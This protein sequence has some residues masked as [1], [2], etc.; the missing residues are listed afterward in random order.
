MPNVLTIDKRFKELLKEKA[1]S[2]RREVPVGFYDRFLMIVQPSGTRSWVLRYGN[3]KLTIGPVLETRSG[4]RP[5]L[6]YDLPMTLH[7]ALEFLKEPLQ[8]IKEG[9]DPASE[10]QAGDDIKSLAETYLTAYAKTHRSGHEVRRQ[11][12]TY[13]LPEWGDRRARDITKRDVRQLHDKVAKR[14]P[15]MAGLMLANLRPFFKSLVKADL[16]PANPCEGVDGAKSGERERVLNAAEIGAFWR[17]CE[18]QGYPFGHMYQMLLL[19]GQRRTEV[20]E[21][22]WAELDAEGA[23]WTIP[24]ERAKNK[25]GHRVPLSAL[26]QEILHSVPRIQDSLYVFT[27]RG[28]T[29]STG[30]SKSKARIDKAMQATEEWDLHDLRR[31]CASGLGELRVAPHVIEAVLNHKSGQIKG[32]ARVYN[33]YDYEDEKRDALD[34]WAHKLAVI[35]A[36]DNVVSLRA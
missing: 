22:R 13:V 27:T 16:I 24:P 35:T 20:A 3:K 33:R 30:Y 15:R 12:N 6:K 25:N 36:G 31:T 26:A 34:A 23:V 8:A 10:K 21:M 11:F 17:A 19:T 5:T 2:A 14:G 18:A 7:E 29:A 4:P 32:V 28:S 1:G 9:R